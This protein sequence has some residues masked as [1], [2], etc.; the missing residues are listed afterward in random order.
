MAYVISLDI[1]FI[2]CFF[3]SI[4][5][6][7][8]VTQTEINLKASH[9]TQWLSKDKR[10]SVRPRTLGNFISGKGARRIGSV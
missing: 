5:V 10:K 7:S 2:S 6:M 1:H 8:T 3:L 9:H 4:F